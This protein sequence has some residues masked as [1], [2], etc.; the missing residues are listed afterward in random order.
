MPVRRPLLVLL[1]AVVL[2]A[3]LVV[4]VPYAQAQRDARDLRDLTAVAERLDLPGEARACDQP[5]EHDALRCI[6][7]DG[8]ARPVAEALAAQVESLGLTSAEID[9]YLPPVPRTNRDGSLVQVPE[10]CLVLSRH[11][12][13]SS[14]LMVGVMPRLLPEP[15]I[16]FEGLDVYVTVWSAD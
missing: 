12:H 9:C 5:G 6:S 16:T 2:L 4:A 11:R 13:G 15:P 3:A 8:P 14:G 10:H 7:L 1:G